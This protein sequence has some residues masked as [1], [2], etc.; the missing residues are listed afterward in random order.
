LLAG[1]TW[2]FGIK[3]IGLFGGLVVNVLLAR[4]LS[5]DEMGAYFLAI[6]VA[7]LGALMVKLGTQQIL[8]RFVAESVTVGAGGRARQTVVRVAGIMLVSSIL[9]CLLLFSG[10]GNW[11]AFELF[12]APRM[13]DVLG[14]LAALVVVLA[15]QS[16][17][18]EAFRGLHRIPQA[19]LFDT[20]LSTLIFALTL[21]AFWIFAGKLYMSDALLLFVCA[22]IMAILVG[23]AFLVGPFRVLPGEGKVTTFEILRA[24]GPIL[25][26]NLSFYFISNAGLW[27]VGAYEPVSEVALYGAVVRL[28]TL[29]S[30]PLSIVNLVMQPYIAEQ[31][32]L[33]R[34]GDLERMLRAAASMAGLPG[35]V[36]LLVFI[37]KGD[38]IMGMIFGESYKAG[39]TLLAIFSLGHIVNVWTGG[40]GNVLIFAGYQKTLMGITLVSSPISFFVALLLVQSR[41]AMGVALAMSGGLVLQNLAS[42]W[43]VHRRVGI[44]THVSSDIPG[45]LNILRDVFAF[46]RQ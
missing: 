46:R 43:F 27:I 32:T 29:I 18:S 14:I 4:L 35:A 10:A 36:L 21:V 41:G 15:F 42:W 13:A 25:V 44:W 20:V 45:I 6:T 11:L 1:G 7:G 22:N 28:V 5:T 34:K 17:V 23:A 2:A 19:S 30:I 39:G 12:D 9:A 26:T 3:I 31:N 24:S 40:C 16:V 38:Y 33:N 8:V 37:F